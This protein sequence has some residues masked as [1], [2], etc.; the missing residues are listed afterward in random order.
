[1]LDSET[2]SL[3]DVVGKLNGFCGEFLDLSIQLHL[4][5]ANQMDV[6]DGETNKNNA[7]KVGPEK[8]LIAGIT[9]FI[10]SFKVVLSGFTGTSYPDNIS[11]QRAVFMPLIKPNVELIMGP[12]AQFDLIP[13]R[14]HIRNSI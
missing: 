4:D 1:L 3:K 11:G 14:G 10:F 13:R 5:Y 6:N 2:A 12:D 8:N 9:S 7:S